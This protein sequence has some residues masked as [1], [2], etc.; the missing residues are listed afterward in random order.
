MSILIEP[1][2]PFYESLNNIDHSLSNPFIKTKNNLSKLSLLWKYNSGQTESVLSKINNILKIRCH[3]YKMEK[4]SSEYNSEFE[5]EYT[6]NI[7]HEPIFVIGWDVDQYNKLKNLVFK[8]VIGT[9]YRNLA[10]RV[11]YIYFNTL[12]VLNNN[13]KLLDNIPENDKIELKNTIGKL[14]EDKNN[15]LD[16]LQNSILEHNFEPI[17]LK[18]VEIINFWDALIDSILIC[19]TL[20]RNTILTNNYKYSRME[21]NS[22]SD[23][24]FNKNRYLLPILLGICQEVGQIINRY[25]H[26]KFHCSMPNESSNIDILDKVDRSN[27]NQN[28]NSHILFRE[29]AKNHVVTYKFNTKSINQSDNHQYDKNNAQIIDQIT[30]DNHKIIVTINSDG[31][32]NINIEHNNNIKNEIKKLVRSVKHCRFGWKAA[33]T[34]D[35]LPCIVKVYIP[36][37][38]KL[39]R[40]SDKTVPGKYRTDQM[41]VIAIYPIIIDHQNKIIYTDRTVD[42]SISLV[43]PSSSVLYLQNDLVKINDLNIDQNK[44]CASGLH[45]HFSIYEALQWFEEILVYQEK[46]KEETYLLGDEP[47]FIPDTLQ[48]IYNLDRISAILNM[49]NMLPLELI[50]IVKKYLFEF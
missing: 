32:N 46:N 11:P 7:N 16:G 27:K 9:Y 2:N 30:V 49:R 50:N 40:C 26:F 8:S 38:A 13:E 34:F 20:I 5:E 45:F 3:I 6:E 44:D 10:I 31:T 18:I 29:Y 21:C 22:P 48:S 35:G 12:Y 37:S 36:N 14:F 28:N 42:A 19:E 43:N 17:E 25:L 39:V 41:E 1:T 24:N 47:K 4:I 33:M 23:I 15:L